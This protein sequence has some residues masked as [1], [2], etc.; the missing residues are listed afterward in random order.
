[1]PLSREVVT[2][3]A[4]AGFALLVLITGP[5]PLR[6]LTVRL[7]LFLTEIDALGLVGATGWRIAT[8]AFMFATLPVLLAVLVGGVGATL[9]QTGPLAHAGALRPKPARINPLTG[10]RRLVGLE[11]LVETIHALANLALVVVGVWWR[12]PPILAP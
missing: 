9:A 11:N 3:A 12:C 4:L 5:A 10:L 2:L 1:V 6:D 8:L 7:R